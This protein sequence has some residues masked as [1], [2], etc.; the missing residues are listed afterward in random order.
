MGYF[1]NDYWEYKIDQSI[2]WFILFIASHAVARYHTSTAGVIQHY[3]SFH[4]REHK[5]HECI[6]VSEFN[7]VKLSWPTLQRVMSCVSIK[8]I[9]QAYCQMSWTPAFH[10]PRF[11]GFETYFEHRPSQ[12]SDLAI[13]SCHYLSWQSAL[14]GKSK[15]QR[16]KE[17]QVWTQFL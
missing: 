13:Y 9:N 3:H 14:V 1:S 12:I 15:E 6:A 4:Q 16:N 5:A 10:F 17:G 11:W 7:W 8:I 2:A